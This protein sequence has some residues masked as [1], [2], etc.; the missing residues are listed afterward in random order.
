MTPTHYGW[1]C[2][3]LTPPPPVT[4]VFAIGKGVQHISLPPFFFLL[5]MKTGHK[6]LWSQNIDP[7][8]IFF[9]LIGERVQNVIAACCDGNAP[10]NFLFAFGGGYKILWQRNVVRRGSIIVWLK[11]IDPLLLLII[12]WTPTLSITLYAC[13]TYCLS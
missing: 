7:L 4:V 6:L 10:T 11:S 13:P 8:L 3:I 9:I 1:H 5:F 12:F 2:K